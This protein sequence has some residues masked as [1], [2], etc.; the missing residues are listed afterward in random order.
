M[1]GGLKT[2]TNLTLAQLVA[3]TVNTTLTVGHALS[4]ETNRCLLCALFTLTTSHPKH[5]H[6]PSFVVDQGRLPMAAGNGIVQSSSWYF[7][8]ACFTANDA[9]QCMLLASCCRYTWPG[10]CSGYCLHHTP[11]H[12]ATNPQMDGQAELTR[13]RDGH[14]S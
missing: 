6:C 2:N 13:Y 12:T 7:V 8:A 3:L 14:S 4:P 1:S 9:M 5:C 10:A 11:V